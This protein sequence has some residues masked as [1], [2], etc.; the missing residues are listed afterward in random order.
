MMTSPLHPRQDFG[1]RL[2]PKI[3]WLEPEHYEIAKNISQNINQ[4][5][6]QWKVY[7]NQLALL[8]FEEWLQEQLPD[9]K[10]KQTEINLQVGEFKVQ[11]ITVDNLIDNFV[12]IPQENIISPKLA[13]HFYVLI[14]VLEEVE[15]LRIHGLIRY[16]ELS[17]IQISKMGANINEGICQISLSD[18]DSQI[19]NLLIYARFLEV[20]AI[21]LPNL[22]SE[23][24]SHIE[25]S[26]DTVTKS[27]VNLGQWWS[28]AFEEGWQSL[29]DILTPQTPVW[30][31]AKSIVRKG[32]IGT[33]SSD[34][35]VR[36]CKLFDFGLLLNGQRFVL[37]LNMRI[38]EN[39][40]IGVLAQIRSPNEYCLPQGLKLKVTLNHNTDE[41]ESEEAIARECDQIIQLAFSEAHGKQFKVQA[42]YQDAVLTEEFVL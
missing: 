2:K 25:K 14:E 4:E 22:S 26:C 30:G 24:I 21:R 16:D 10:V 40:E 32:T 19:D 39:Q 31:Y 38:E 42:I 35:A 8:G 37:I 17:R 23:L 28:G 20:E 27:I 7:L 3:A 33:R 36:R 6:N 34:F 1:K 11:L 41:A 13:A 18:F 15:Q 29:E 9:I 5:N 12:T